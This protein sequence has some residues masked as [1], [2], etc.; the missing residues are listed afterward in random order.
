MSTRFTF[1]FSLP[2]TAAVSVV[3]SGLCDAATVTGSWA[4]PMT[5]PGPDG[6]FSAYDAQPG[7]TRSDA[8]SAAIGAAGAM[9]ISGVAGADCAVSVEQAGSANS[10]VADIAATAAILY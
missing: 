9:V 4:I 10:A 1:G 2:E 3:S 6:T 7:P 5:D 8:G